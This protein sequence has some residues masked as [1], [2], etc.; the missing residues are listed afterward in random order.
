MAGIHSCDVLV[1]QR[2]DQ[3]GAVIYGTQEELNELVKDSVYPTF[4]ETP[5]F[6]SFT[7]RFLWDQAAIDRVFEIYERRYPNYPVT[8]RNLEDIVN[9]LL[10]IG[11]PRLNSA[12]VAEVTG[13]EPEQLRK[14]REQRQ[15]REEIDSDL[16]E[17]GF[18]GISTVAIREKIR[19]RPEYNK[20]YREMRT[21][22][23]EELDLPALTQDV[24]DFALNYHAARASDLK[25][26]GGIRRIN[27]TTYGNEAYD[28]LLAQAVQH[29]LI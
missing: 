21:P 18:G 16:G 13:P 5:A 23:V 3:R 1:E 12:V 8:C 15:L 9:D 28:R 14:A 17:K 4:F 29:G 2:V 24:N 25:Q 22:Q 27:G 10:L 11:D 6:A 20:M 19:T 26:Q 7:E